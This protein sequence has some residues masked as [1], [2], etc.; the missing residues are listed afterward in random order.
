MESSFSHE[1]YSTI[2]S[3]ALRNI[4]ESIDLGGQRKDI[5]THS[6][7]KGSATFALS[8]CGISSSAIFL[9]AGW[10]LGSTQ[11]RY[12]HTVPGS[13]QIVGRTI[14]GLLV[15]SMEFATLPPHFPNEVNNLIATV[16]GWGNILEHY[17][18]Y[19]N[20]FKKVIPYLLASL[21]YHYNTKFFE[22]N[23]AIG[24]PIW[25]SNI[26]TVPVTIDGIIFENVVT[27]LQDKVLTGRNFCPITN[28]QA[29][30]IP[31]HFKIAEE[32]NSMKAR[33]EEL[34][35]YI[36]KEYETIREDFKAFPN[37]LSRH[38]LDNFQVDGVQPVTQT[39]LQET[40]NNFTT[41]LLQNI[42][43][44][45]QTNHTSKRLMHIFPKDFR[46]TNMSVKQLWNLWHFGNSGLH[47]YPYKLVKERKQFYDLTGKKDKELF[48]KAA[49]VMSFI[50]DHATTTNYNLLQPLVNL[51]QT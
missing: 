21:V 30:G 7:R 26:F 15:Q 41:N 51:Y 38:I 36:K 50:E 27:F 8:V 10:S 2:L 12:V 45:L 20:C 39:F 6:N 5:G 23:F 28:M 46:F 40:L 4:P 42:I 44:R 37:V 22:S 24:H 47:I 34:H 17:E 1:R 43:P 19:P 31:A 16:I 3:Q 9:R 14:C 49:R 25:N 18:N 13:D 32:V 33:M 48:S 11:D 29:T 35:D